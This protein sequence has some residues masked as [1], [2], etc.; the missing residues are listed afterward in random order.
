MTP[1]RRVHINAIMHEIN[2][3]FQEHLKGKNCEP[4]F[5]AWFT[6]LKAPI[7]GA[8]NFLCG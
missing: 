7:N 5:E 1:K 3:M 6:T 8:F 2:L 4:V